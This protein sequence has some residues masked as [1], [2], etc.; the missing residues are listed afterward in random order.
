M[1]GTWQTKEK[2]CNRQKARIQRHLR[3]SRGGTSAQSCQEEIWHGTDKDI[4]KGNDTGSHSTVYFGIEFAQDTLCF[5]FNLFYSLAKRRFLWVLWGKFACCSVDITWWLSRGYWHVGFKAAVTELAGA[6]IV[7]YAD[8]DTIKALWNKH[9]Q[10]MGNLWRFVF[11]L[12]R[13]W[14]THIFRYIVHPF[15]DLRGKN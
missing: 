2:G 9:L 3:K 8:I 10:R 15:W 12:C 14:N 7:S 1:P 6:L 4:F 5:S 13:Q 11:W